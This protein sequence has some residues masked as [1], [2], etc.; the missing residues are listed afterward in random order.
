MKNNRGLSPPEVPNRP[1]SVVFPLSGAK[2]ANIR[3]CLRY[4]VAPAALARFI[5]SCKDLGCPRHSAALP[6]H[7]AHCCAA[8]SPDPASFSL[9]SCVVSVQ[10]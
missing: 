7:T 8:L 5:I 9:A 10:A 6:K 2:H 1:P 4:G 3:L